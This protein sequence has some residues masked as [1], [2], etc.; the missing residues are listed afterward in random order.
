MSRGNSVGRTDHRLRP[1][2]AGSV[3]NLDEK[4]PFLTHS[5]HIGRNFDEDERKPLDGVSG[6]RR[7]ISDESA[8]AQTSEPKIENLSGVRVGSRNTSIHVSQISSGSTGSS[9][10]GRVGEVQNARP[11]TQ[12][13]VGSRGYG[14]N[15]P[16]M[17][18]NAGQAVAGS[19]PNAWGIRKETASLKE[20]LSAAWSAPDAET[21]LAHASALEKVSSGRWNSKQ[22]AH[23]LRDSEILGHLETEGQFEFNSNNI[24]NKKTY[25][26]LDV[27]GDSDHDIDLMIH[28]E[29]SLAVDDGTRGGGGKEMR[30]YER[31]RSIISGESHERKGP[32]TANGFQSPHPTGKSGI[33]ESQPVLP[34]ESSDRP[35]LK[36]LPRSKPLENLETSVD[37][38]QV[39]LLC[40]TLR[41]YL[42]L[43][44][45][46]SVTQ[47]INHFCTQGLEQ[48]SDHLLVEDSYVIHEPKIP[49]QPGFAGSV[50]VDRA[51]ERPKLNLKPRSQPLEQLEGKSEVKRS[52][53]F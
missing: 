39:N 5:S 42:Y 31:A 45:L 46:D 48:T 17:G 28:A 22:H 49:L 9:Y 11:N 53:D 29:R 32:F 7:T 41:S 2:S 51:P 47:C 6:P 34:A 21:K 40:C 52:T 14:S 30:T 18:G 23:P 37:F 33:T 25:N 16:V 1:A 10:A 4:T 3:R 27:V 50:V 12:S 24:Y 20:P 44:K 8:R 26:M 15:Y 36:L 13:S 43:Y 38:K 35:K 19:Y